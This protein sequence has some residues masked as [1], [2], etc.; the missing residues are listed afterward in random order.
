MRCNPAN[1]RVT[2]LWMV[3]MAG[4]D[5][6][7]YRQ[8]QKVWASLEPLERIKKGCDPKKEKKRILRFGPSSLLKV[9]QK[10]KSSPKNRW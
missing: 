2:L 5:F 8:V 7:N 10:R 3:A 6:M 1:G 9:P 4:G